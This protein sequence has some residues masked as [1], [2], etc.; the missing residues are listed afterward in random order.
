[1]AVPAP[2]VEEAN[3]GQE[4]VDGALAELAM[5]EGVSEQV[6][7]NQINQEIHIEIM[8]P[9]A[10]AL[11]EKFATLVMCD[12][13][14]RNPSELPAS[15]WVSYSHLFRLFEPHVPAEVWLVGP[16][17]L[18][19]LITKWYQNRPAFL[20]LAPDAWS[21]RRKDQS[22]PESYIYKFSFEYT[23]Q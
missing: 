11:Q 16:G 23:P 7:S 18:K 15:R 22:R 3:Y 13:T 20:G 17:N 4:L 6:I 19:C 21:K 8:P 1:M 9:S 5:E 10:L 12:F 14:P 2:S